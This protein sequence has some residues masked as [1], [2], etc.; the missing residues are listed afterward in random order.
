MCV[1][2]RKLSLAR[3]NPTAGSKQWWYVVPYVVVFLLVV[4]PV[5][6][7]RN[8]VFIDKHDVSDD[9]DR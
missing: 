3:K 7:E 2:K 5:H 9:I 1:V 8:V 4:V 6:I